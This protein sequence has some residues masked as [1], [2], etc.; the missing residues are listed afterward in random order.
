MIVRVLAQNPARAFY[1]R[2]GGQS[3]GLRMIHV[4]GARVE[5]AA[6]VWRDLGRRA[7]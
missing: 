5:E 7:G 3:A 1:A 2:L 6:Y 4:G